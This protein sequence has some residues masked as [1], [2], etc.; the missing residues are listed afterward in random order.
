M[1]SAPKGPPA[2]MKTPRSI[3]ERMRGSMTGPHTR[4]HGDEIMRF[5][6]G[7]LAARDEAARYVLVSAGGIFSAEDAYRR[8]RLGASLVQVYT[9]L[10]YRGPSLVKDIKRGLC[11]LLDRDGYTNI[12]QAIGADW[13]R[14][15]PGQGIATAR[16]A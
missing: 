16:A 3:Y 5:W 9:A 14:Q 10:I 4:V 13:P 11:E 7:R 1:P 8:I 12:S 6:Y 2:T 15:A